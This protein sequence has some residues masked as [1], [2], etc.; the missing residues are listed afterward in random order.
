REKRKGFRLAAIALTAVCF[1]GCK[2]QELPQESIELLAPVEAVVDIET[3]LY[4]DL[5]TLTTKEAELAPHTEELAFEAG[6]SVSKLYVEIG[7]EVKAGDL[8]AEQEED[9]VR[10]A[11]ENALNKYLTEKKAYLDAVKSARKKLASGIGGDEKEW[12]ELLIRQ[13]EETWAMQEPGLW[14]AWETAKARVG[15]SKIYA[16]YDG[17]VTACVGLGTEIAA[18]QPVLALADTT[19]QYITVGSYLAPSEYE[20]YDRV[21]AFINGKET[22][23]TYEEELMQEEGLLTYYTAEN[24]N[25]AK[26]GDF[27]LVCMVSDLHEQV[28]SIPNNALYKDS[29]GSYVYL[30]RDGTRIRQNVTTGYKNNVYTEIVDGLEEGDQVYVKN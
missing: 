6:G 26:I 16:P 28:L 8:L 2:T 20:T 18:G 22:E 27:I 9:G 1:T 13:A 21:Y 25:G 17:V 30:M 7:S 5:Y 15:N 11:A 14:E 12:Q 4:R 24:L 19:R 23:I 10:K 29:L 3:A